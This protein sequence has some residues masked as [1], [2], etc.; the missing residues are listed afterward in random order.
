EGIFVRGTFLE[1]A[2]WDRK[3]M[4]LTEPQPMQL[5]CTMPV[6]HFKPVENLKKKTRGIYVSPCYYYPIRSGSGSRPS[7]VVA[8]DLKCGNEKPDHWIKRGTALLL[9]LAN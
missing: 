1:G 3:L 4:I 8:V 6:I 5:V 9:S 7:Y 2:G